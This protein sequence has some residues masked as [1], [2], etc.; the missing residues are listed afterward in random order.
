MLNNCLKAFTHNIL[1]NNFNLPRCQCTV[2]AVTL[3]KM[4]WQHP[5]LACSLYTYTDC[6]PKPS[7]FCW[8]LAEGPHLGLCITN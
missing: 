6:H 4:T 8:D 2:D 7:L 5:E 1:M 3:V